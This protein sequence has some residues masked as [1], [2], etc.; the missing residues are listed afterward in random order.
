MAILGGALLPPL[1]GALADHVGIRFSFLVPMLA[2]AYLVFY[3]LVGC[4]IGRPV[5]A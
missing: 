1:Q 3:G 2:Y 5:E 4:R